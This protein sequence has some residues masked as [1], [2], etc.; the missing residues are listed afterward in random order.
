MPAKAVTANRLTD[1]IVVFY[2]PSFRWVENLQHAALFASKDEV[3]AALKRAGSDVTANIVV[4]PFDFDV[5]EENGKLRAAHLRDA[6]RADG[7][8]VHLDH[9][10]QAE[11]RFS[12]SGSER[13]YRCIATMN[14]MPLS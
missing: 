12:D 2:D 7:P 4:D 8:T 9:G 11:K 14:S 5:I 6:I 10:K 3:A 13:R 1:G